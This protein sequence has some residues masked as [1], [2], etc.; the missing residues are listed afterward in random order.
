MWDLPSGQDNSST[1]SLATVR[2]A[3]EAAMPE[4]PDFKWIIRGKRQEVRTTCHLPEFCSPASTNW[5]SLWPS[6]LPG[7]A[8]DL[9]DCS[10]IFFPFHL[11]LQLSLPYPFPHPFPTTL[12]G[13]RVKFKMGW[14]QARHQ[15]N[16]INYSV[17]RTLRNPNRAKLL[18]LT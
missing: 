4:L 2:K 10:W 17:Q 18:C 5:W 15:N 14:G 6:A 9:G 1:S 16:E 7:K 13:K 11:P 12:L 3:V 8:R